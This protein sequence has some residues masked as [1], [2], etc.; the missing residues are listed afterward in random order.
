MGKFEKGH[1]K[2][3]G[4][5]KGDKNK[6]TK[7]FKEILT[8]TIHALEDN[9]DKGEDE[10]KTGL[11]EFAKKNPKEFYRIASKLVP[12]EMVGELTGEVTIRV[13]RDGANS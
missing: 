4:R 1:E 12:Q 6:V 11:L 2:L 8:E 7:A 9:S 10:A 5:Q 13:L 3:G